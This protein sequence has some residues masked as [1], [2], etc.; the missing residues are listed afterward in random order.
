[1]HSAMSMISW[2]V[3]GPVIFRDLIIWIIGQTEGAQS[4]LG[5]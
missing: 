2:G 5:L 1:M 3:G 4:G